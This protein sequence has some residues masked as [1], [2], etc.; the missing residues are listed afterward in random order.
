MTSD[1]AF[2]PHPFCTKGSA[3]DPQLMP[4]ALSPR[5]QVRRARGRPKCLQAAGALALERA[6]WI[7]PEGKGSGYTGL[8]CSQRVGSLPG[9]LW[10]CPSILFHFLLPGRPEQEHGILAHPFSWVSS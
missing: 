7:P 8:S 1:L 5:P 10:G 2:F 4:S 9:P 3:F 6:P